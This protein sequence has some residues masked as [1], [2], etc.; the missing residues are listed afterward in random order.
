MRGSAPGAS[1][2]TLAKDP[3][4][5]ASPT[6]WGHIPGAKRRSITPYQAREPP[7]DLHPPG[8][9]ALGLVI[10][11]GGIEPDHASLVAEGL[12][13]CF[14]IVDQRHDDFAVTRHVDLADER[15]VAVEDA[16]VDHR[17][18]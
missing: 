3:G 8:V 6:A 16:L 18:A 11:V 13:G 1:R 4:S 9:V 15:E 17:I 12:E 2:S 14:L 10:A 5:T 7:L